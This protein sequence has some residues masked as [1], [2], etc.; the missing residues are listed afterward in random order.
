MY[1][2]IREI[3]DRVSHL[4]PARQIN[5]PENA[6]TRMNYGG[7]LLQRVALPPVS[8][9]SNAPFNQHSVCN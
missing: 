3:E 6:E 2:H 9:A 7:N 8:Q 5:H 1:R 4:D